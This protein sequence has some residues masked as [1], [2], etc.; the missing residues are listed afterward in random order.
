MADSVPQPV[1]RRALLATLHQFFPVDG[2]SSYAREWFDDEQA[3]PDDDSVTERRKAV[4]QLRVN[5]AADALLAQM[6]VPTLAPGTRSIV[7]TDT[8][9]LH[10]ADD[11]QRDTRAKIGPRL[12][13][14]LVVVDAAQTLIKHHFPDAQN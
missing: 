3:L 12:T 5:R 11:L 13:A 14:A 2:L 9:L 8:E 1:D 4:W 7:L 10:L 6:D